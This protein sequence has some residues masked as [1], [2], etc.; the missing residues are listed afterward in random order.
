MIVMILVA[1]AAC[2]ALAY[3]AVPL[4]REHTTDLEEHWA[5]EQAGARKQTALQAIVDLEE[6][7]AVGKLS[8][9]DFAALRDQYEAEALVA[10]KELDALGTPDDALEAEIAALRV[11]LECPECGGLRAGE[12]V[13]PQCG[14]R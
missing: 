3:V 11:S 12:R 7:R 1:L 13:C 5:A 9:V 14:A 4:R 8:A 2:A 6:E 10:L